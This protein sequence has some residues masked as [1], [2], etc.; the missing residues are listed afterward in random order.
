MQA[1]KKKATARRGTSD[2]GKKDDSMGSLSPN[3]EN[4]KGGIH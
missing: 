4:V 3:Q 1:S 2:S